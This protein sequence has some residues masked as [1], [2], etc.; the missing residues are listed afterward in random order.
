M[1]TEQLEKM[2]KLND[3]AAYVQTGEAGMQSFDQH[4][5][6]MH[7]A[8]QI[9]GTEA[10]RWATNPEALAIAMRGIKRIGGIA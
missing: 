1:N 2:D 10:L 5:L 3:L 8:E 9:S 7:K 4:L 6:A